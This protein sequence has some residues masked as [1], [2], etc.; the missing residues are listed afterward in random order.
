MKCHMISTWLYTI[1]NMNW[2]LFVERWR[3]SYTLPL[4]HFTSTHSRFEEFSIKFFSSYLILGTAFVE[5]GNSINLIL[6][7]DFEAKTTAS[8][9]QNTRECQ[10]SHHIGIH[11][12]ITVTKVLRDYHVTQ[13]A[14]FLSDSVT[15]PQLKSHYSVS[16]WNYPNFLWIILAL[17]S[18]CECW[19]NTSL[20]VWGV[21]KKTPELAL[22]GRAFVI[23]IPSS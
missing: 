14:Q 2:Q 17:Y 5:D 18:Y 4:S 21:T 7:L 3:Q 22:S 15:Q 1:K 16:D 13:D 8:E 20:W 12:L 9:K 11:S 23:Q 6:L 10:R 19:V